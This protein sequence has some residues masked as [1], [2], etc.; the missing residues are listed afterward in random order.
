MKIEQETIAQ[1]E[2]KLD[3]E[4]KKKINDADSYFKLHKTLKRKH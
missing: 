2:I 4:K 3:T 1:L